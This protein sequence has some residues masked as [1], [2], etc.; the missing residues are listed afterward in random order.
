LK[1]AALPGRHFAAADEK[2]RIQFALSQGTSTEEIVTLAIDASSV[3]TV[4]EDCYGP[5]DELELRQRQ[6]AVAVER[7]LEGKVKARQGLDRGA[8]WLPRR[9]SHAG[10]VDVIGCSPGGVTQATC[11]PSSWRR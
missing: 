2:G 3:S 8:C 9:F 7:G 11:Y 10:E 5:V 1:E 4:P 6:N